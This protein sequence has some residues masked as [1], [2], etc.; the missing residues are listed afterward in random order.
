[1][2]WPGDY[3]QQVGIGQKGSG[4]VHLQDIIPAFISR[5]ENYGGFQ[6]RHIPAKS[7]ITKT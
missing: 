7:D 3:E 4:H 5:Q 2:H 6:N 1:M